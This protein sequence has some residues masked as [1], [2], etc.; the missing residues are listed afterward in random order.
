MFPLPAFL[1]PCASLAVALAAGS[2]LWA[3]SSGDLLIDYVPETTENPGSAT[4][5]N[6]LVGA[7]FLYDK[8]YV[9]FNAIVANV[10][11]GHIWFG[12]DVFHRPGLTFTLSF[13]N[14]GGA[15]EIDFHATAVG[16]VLAGTGY[17]AA[18]EDQPEGYT[19]VGVGIA[20]F[21]ELWSGAIAEAF[22][23]TTLGEFSTSP[24]LTIAPYKAF[25]NGINETRPD[26][27]NSSWGGADPGGIDPVTVALD[28][29]AKQNPTVAF[30]V[31]A[32]NSGEEVVGSPGSGYN[33]I[34]VG[35]VGGA[36]LLTPS[37]FSSRG[38]ADFHLPGNPDAIGVRAA[39]DIAAPGENFVLAAYLGDTGSLGASTDPDLAELVEIAPTPGWY[40]LELDGTSFAA[41]VVAGGIA[42][43]KEAAKDPVNG[44][45]ADALDTRVVK[46]VVMASARETTGWNNGQ[47]VREDGVIVTTQALDYTTGA[48][49]LDL[50]AAYGVYIE[51]TTGLVESGDGLLLAGGW[52]LGTIATTEAGESVSY[53]FD[54]PFTE[55]TELTVSLNWF[56]DRAFDNS[57]DIGSEL[58]FA[59]LDL[60]I[61]MYGEETAPLL[62]AESISL[63]NNAEFLRI[64]LD[65]PGLYG[66]TIVFEG[67]IYDLTSGG[68]TSETYGVAW[69]AVT[70][71]EPSTALFTLLGGGV[72][73]LFA[74]RKSAPRDPAG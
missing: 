26:V 29:L 43:L 51:G 53:Q 27:I 30:V 60:Q 71:P 54:S 49:A 8:G 73:M 50:Q 39:V 48:G 52:D 9:G 44:L 6:P 74:R 19:Y 1:R 31:S 7:E 69:Q 70:I 25:F 68:V 41:P 45:S 23:S 37:E 20:P 32:G 67:M 62:V 40:F 55:E 36:D 57:T 11:G 66:I 28:G 38:P 24:E 72:L 17:V 16:H 12:H 64:T 47:Y 46:S 61:W 35:S 10:E 21:A 2:S 14:P 13:D 15:N 33:N 4:Y 59:N 34:A 58:S 63:Y 3:Q 56:A 22:S 42:L 5:L 18:T 65:T